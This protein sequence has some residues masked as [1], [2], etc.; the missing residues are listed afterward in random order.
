[1]H[2]GGPSAAFA[3]QGH[4]LGNEGL[5]FLSGLVLV[6]KAFEPRS[7]VYI[8]HT[9]LFSGAQSGVGGLLPTPC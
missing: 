4:P 3:S 8:I 7:M 2:V 5:E 1:M 9:N 6:Q